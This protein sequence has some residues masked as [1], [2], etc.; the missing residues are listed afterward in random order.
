MFEMPR[1]VMQYSL[2]GAQ[3]L[4]AVVPFDFEGERWVAAMLAPADAAVRVLSAEFRQLG[5]LMFA[6]VLALGLTTQV[7]WVHRRRRIQ[8]EA[9]AARREHLERSHSELTALNARLEN[10]A[11]EWRTTVDTIDAA[12][13]VFDPLGKIERMNRAASDTLPGEPFSWLDVPS[14]QL[15]FYPP[16]DSALALAREA[17]ETQAASAARVHHAATGRTWDLWCRAPRGRGSVVA[18]ARD[19][20]S[21]VELQQSLRRSETMAALGSVVVGVAHEVRNPL[22]AMSSLVDAWSVQTHRDPSPFLD[23]LRHEVGRVNTLMTELLEYGRPT[24][25][26]LQPS[27]LAK[28]IEEAVHACAPEAEQRGVRVVAEALPDVELWMD[29][30]RL[31]RVFINLIQNAIQHSPAET[32]V[33]VGVGLRPASHPRLADITVRDRGRGFSAEDLPRLFTPFFSRRPGGFGLGLAI[34][35]RIVAEHRGRATAANHPEGGAIV[36]VT[37]PL[38]PPERPTRVGQGVTRVEEPHP[39]GR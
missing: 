32:S 13:M 1:G 33:S 18:V 27:A 35:E 37:L 14:E 24:K 19:T 10:A 30:R 7:T 34:S 39:V 26:V 5:A 31:V 28:V 17:V 11:V 29:A 16:W 3:Q 2:R 15:A 21:L 4:G 9:E 25:V 6:T 22:F 36:T 12:L 38:T 20:T 23:A 8:A